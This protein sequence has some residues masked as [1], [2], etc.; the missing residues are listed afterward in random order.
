MLWWGLQSS[1]PAAVE[2]VHCVHVCAQSCLTLCHPMGFS[3]RLGPCFHGIFQARILQW[4]AFS[5]PG[6]LPDPG[7]EPVSLVSPALAGGFLEAIRS[8]SF[9]PSL[10]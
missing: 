8:Q 6:I 1:A 3:P 5:S 2:L 10:A 7:I 4:V 9:N